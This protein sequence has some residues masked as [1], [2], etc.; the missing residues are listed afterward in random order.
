MAIRSLRYI[1]TLMLSGAILT[2]LVGLASVWF[3]RSLG[4]I[5]GSLAPTLGLDADTAEM[6]TEIFDQLKEASLNLPLEI[7]GLVCFLFC[8]LAIL[9]LVGRR[10]PETP[11]EEIKEEI[12]TRKIPRN[13][14]TGKIVLVCVL[15]VILFLPLTLV[16]IWFTEVNDIRFDRVMATLI[17]LLNSGI[18]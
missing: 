8:G 13:K 2:I 12:E 1:A 3:L 16:T 15:G 7:I 5:L 18:L 17:P 14:K 9:F 11:A 6:L 10:V 4:G